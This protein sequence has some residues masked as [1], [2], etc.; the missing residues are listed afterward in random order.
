[1]P[2][3]PSIRSLAREL[4]LSVATVSEALYF[5]RRLQEYRITPR[6][7]VVNRV[8]RPPPAAPS[9]SVLLAALEPLISLE[10]ARILLPKLNAASADAWDFARRDQQGVAQLREQL[11][12]GIDYTEVPAFDKDVHDLPSLARLAAHFDSGAHP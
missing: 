5:G 11:D 10:Q 2:A 1:M 12:L 4:D 9:D 7:L 6:A 3:P 8:H